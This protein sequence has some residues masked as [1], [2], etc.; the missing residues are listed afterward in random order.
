MDSSDTSLNYRS[1]LAEIIIGLA[2]MSGLVLSIAALV[3]ICSSCSV[4]AGYSAFGMDFGWF[5]ISYFAILSVVVLLRGRHALF[6]ALTGIMLFSSAG[7]ESYFI[8]IQKYEIGQWCSIC[9]GIAA[10]VFVACLGIALAPRTEFSVKGETMKSKL[11]Y[12]VLVVI[13]FMTGLGSAVAGVKK[14]GSSAPDQFLGKRSSKTIVY[15]VSDWFCPVCVRV[16][17][18]IE[19]MYPELAKTVKI[20]FVDFP[21]HKESL[22]YTPYNLQFLTF[23]KGKY[24]RLRKALSTLALR[25]KNP[26]EAE[27]QSAVMP[28]GVKLR[29]MDYAE[30][31]SGMRNNESVYRGFNVNA[32]PSVVVTNQR[33]KKSKTLVG[34]EQINEHLIRAAI[35]EV[36]KK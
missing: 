30:T 33:T 7:A 20:G 9:L 19:K 17:P 6:R 21:I 15:F 31:L 26:T 12:L 14:A 29:K 5:G 1:V 16:E 32:T 11:I 8:W 2:T 25:T 28:L 3:K 36:E 4:T 23:E 18:Q 22:N 34:Y 13:V 10:S 27:V 35:A 24:M